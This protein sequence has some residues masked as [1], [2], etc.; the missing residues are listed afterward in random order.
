MTSCS[1]P[2][3][4]RTAVSPQIRSKQRVVEFNPIKKKIALLQL[5]NES[6]FGGEDLAIQATEELRREISRTRDFMVDTNA[7]QLFGSSKEI[8]SGGGVKL[9]QLTR[10]AKMAGVSLV[11]FGRV[12][13]ARI[14]SSNDEI[15]FVRKVKAMAESKV[16]FKVFDVMSSKEILSETVDGVVNDDNYKFYITEEEETSSYRQD[17][18]RFSTRVAVRKFVPQVVQLGS[19]LDWTG[20]VAKIIGTKIYINAGRESG[21]HMGDIL[22]VVTEG[23]EVYDPETGALIGISKGDVKGTLE[24]TDYFGPDGAIAVLHSGGSVTEG[25]F[26]QLY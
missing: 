5:F 8:Y 12:T 23:N 20:R 26:V 4:R 24:V 11:I 14:R 22:K 7:A 1:L 25:D 9:A 6:P 3:T 19:K 17:L 10:K 15:G 18:L 13:E 21:V 16:E 2:I